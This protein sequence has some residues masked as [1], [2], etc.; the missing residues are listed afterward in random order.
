MSETEPLAGIDA[1]PFAAEFPQLVT[2]MKRDGIP[3]S[4]AA[5]EI[6]A[7]IKSRK[8][9]AA[10]T[11]TGVG[12]V[13]QYVAE[14]EDRVKKAKAE[15]R[16]ITLA[17]ASAELQ[18]EEHRDAAAKWEARIDERVAIAKA[19]GR[20]IGP[21]DAIAELQR[22]EAGDPVDKLGARIQ[23]LIDSE[24]AQG[25]KM[26]YAEAAAQVQREESQ[27]A[28]NIG[29]QLDAQIA[30]AKAD[31]RNIGPA[32]AMAELEIAGAAN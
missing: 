9:S 30:K 24:K 1:L 32:H 10:G 26:H 20:R 6:V 15:G 5:T 8:A 28:P 4:I 17:I 7:A 27:S 3:V 25:R 29:A 21:V 11:S 31:G 13:A 16:T 23:A 18:R 12:D 2:Q 14:L 22:E 19:E